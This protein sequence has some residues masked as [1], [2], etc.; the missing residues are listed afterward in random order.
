MLT[1]AAELS[2]SELIDIQRYPLADA[3][4]RQRIAAAARA[5]LDTHGFCALPG[6]LRSEAIGA[7]L[8]EVTRLAPAAHY[9]DILLGAYGGDADPGLPA[10]HPRRRRHPFRMGVLAYDRFPAQSALRRLYLHDD[11]TDLVAVVLGEPELHRCAD[12]LLSCNVTIMAPGGQHGWHFDGNDFVVTILLQAAEHGG[13]FEFAPGIRSDRDEN[14][15]AVA[16]VMDGERALTRRP[17]VSPGTLML[18]R[19]KHS[20][21]RVSPVEGSRPRIVAIFSYDRRPD[22]VFT[23]YVQQNAVGRVAPG[24]LAN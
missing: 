7:V 6:F 15:D 2:P 23:P 3:V 21:H 24:H 12:P 20:L 9:R 18:F 16:R 13:E 1:D 8:E 5:E 11:L 22:M 4:A 19:G 14:Y 17:A 10:G